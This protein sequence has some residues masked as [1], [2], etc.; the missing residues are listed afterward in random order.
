M[1]IKIKQTGNFKKT[2]KFL[3]RIS[4]PS[5]LADL[6]ALAMEGVNAL[7]LY[8]PKD[9]GETATSWGY[10]IKI[11]PSGIRI[12]WTNY[13]LVDG[14]PLVILLQYGHASRDNGYVEG[15]DFINPAMRPVFDRIEQEVWKEVLRA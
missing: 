6:N 7:S 8:T 5:K 3:N 4:S 13:N 14:V 10:E 11:D 2:E 15:Q 9:T 1:R 12:F